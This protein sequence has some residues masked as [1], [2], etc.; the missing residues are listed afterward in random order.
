MVLSKAIDELSDQSNIMDAAAVTAGFIMSQQ[1]FRRVHSRIGE[2][3]GIGFIQQPNELDGI[4]TAAV[5][6]GYGNQV[7]STRTADM[8]ATGGLVDTID[9]I[10]QRAGVQDA[11]QGV[12]N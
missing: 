5:F 9:K 3:A 11:L 10:S 6:Y 8:I 7:V 1:V 12:G 2:A 4:V